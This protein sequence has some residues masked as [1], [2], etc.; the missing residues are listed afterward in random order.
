VVYSSIVPAP[1]F[2]TKRLDPDKRGRQMVPQGSRKGVA[3]TSIVVAAIAMGGLSK[4]SAPPPMVIRTRTS[5]PSTLAVLD[6]VSTNRFGMGS[7][8]GSFANLGTNAR[9]CGTCHVEANA[10]TFTPSHA[11]SL[12]SNDPLFTPNDGSGRWCKCTRGSDG[13]RCVSRSLGPRL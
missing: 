10:W 11:Q 8:N 2:V 5:R 9:T 7:T 4:R 13:L 1:A 3:F 6:S 12:A